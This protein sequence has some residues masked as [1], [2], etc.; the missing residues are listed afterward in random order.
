MI[1]SLQALFSL[2]GKSGG[3]FD[4]VKSW[5]GKTQVEVD[6]K[7]KAPA[8]VPKHA[9]GTMS[10]PG[11]LSLIG[12]NGPE[13]VDLP[14]GSRVYNNSET[15]NMMSKEITVNLNIGG[16]VIGNDDF[17]AQVSNALGRQLQTALAV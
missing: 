11:G 7:L 15:K 4:K 14:Q 2:L 8:K 6:A 17:I 1:R 3:V 10:A 16:N 9:L 5:A 13:L 12:E